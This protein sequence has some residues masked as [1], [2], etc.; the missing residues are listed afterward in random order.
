MDRYVASLTL[1]EA[2]YFLSLDQ[3]YY[4]SYN[5]AINAFVIY[6]INQDAWLSGNRSLAVRNA[7]RTS[8]STLQKGVTLVKN[9]DLRYITAFYRSR[10][11]VTIYR[12]SAKKYQRILLRAESKIIPKLFRLRSTNSITEQEYL[13]ALQNYNDY[14][15]NFSISVLYPKNNEALIRYQSAYAKTIATYNKKIVPKPKV[16]TPTPTPV[17]PLTEVTTK[18]KVGDYYSFTRVLKE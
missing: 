4:S 11:K 18:K 10:E 8:L 13:S 7:R 2:N 16:T 9:H 3:S 15:L 1:R 17:K 6:L 12:T 5:Q 14:V